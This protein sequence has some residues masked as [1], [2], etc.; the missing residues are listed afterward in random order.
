MKHC[1]H[2][3]D[4]IADAWKVENHLLSVNLV[5]NLQLKNT[6][7]VTVIVHVEALVSLLSAVNVEKAGLFVTKTFGIF[8][9]QSNKI[10]K[11]N[12]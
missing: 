11:K 9:G 4:I 1:T 12:S 6:A 2:I 5:Y 7:I 3:K 10:V 8:F